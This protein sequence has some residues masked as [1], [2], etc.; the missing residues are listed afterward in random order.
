MD[1]S[2]ELTERPDPV[3]APG[4]VLVRV[5]AAS[6]NYRDV[7]IAR[8][9]VDRPVVPVSDGAGEV[10]AVGEGVE[11]WRVGDRVVGN[12]FRTWVDGPWHPSYAASALGGAVDGV[13]AELV[14]FPSDAVTAV[15]QSW[16]DEEAA[17]LPC[18]AVTAWNALT[19]APQ[20]L[21]RGDLLL[22]QGTGGVSIFA[23]QLGVA[24]GAEVLVT[25][26]SDE[27]L[28]T[29]IGLGA[30]FGVNYLSRPD[31]AA[32]ARERAGRGATHVVEV[33]GQLDRSL[34]AAASG[35]TIAIVGTTLGG[36]EGS[37]VDAARIQ[38][39][40][41]T[42]RGV[43]VGSVAM[44]DAVAKELASADRRPVID[45]VIPFDDAPAAYAALA[46]A[47]HVGKIVIRF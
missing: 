19:A 46:A 35:A 3:A 10:V 22:V 18:A 23:L 44:L 39:K 24:R 27:K 25:S 8:R 29:A 28:A 21:G 36:D 13:L 37:S 4:E 1:A 5:G 41:A 34:A 15:P 45:T 31:W 26:S 42:I 33:T 17:T 32:A 16:S 30:T 38:Q 2:L 12:F 40:L 14:S 9:G 47:G 43:F 20:A 11:R 6:L 7:A